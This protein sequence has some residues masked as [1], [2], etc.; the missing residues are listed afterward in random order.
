MS[1]E[2]V[3]LPFSSRRPTYNFHLMSD[4][5][6]VD[7]LD[8]VKGEE[9]ARNACL[10]LVHVTLSLAVIVI[11]LIIDLRHKVSSSHLQPS[12]AI[13]DRSIHRSPVV[14]ASNIIPFRLEFQ[15]HAP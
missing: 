4:G 6:K 9:F 1:L 12:P 11:D 8:D 13:H 14:I 2:E 15:I 3:A 7:L 5:Q 10:E